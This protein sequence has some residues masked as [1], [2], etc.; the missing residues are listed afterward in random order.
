MLLSPTL[1][2]AH[3]SSLDSPLFFASRLNPVGLLSLHRFFLIRPPSSIIA[4]HYL[5]AVRP[6]S[7]KIRS[8]N[9]RNS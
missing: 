5:I 9:L 3:I 7:S 4:H 1:L 6:V 8:A 2:S